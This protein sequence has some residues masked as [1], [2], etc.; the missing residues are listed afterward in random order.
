MHRCKCVW[1]NGACFRM[2]CV[3]QVSICT[4]VS[5]RKTFACMRMGGGGGGKEGLLSSSAM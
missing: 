1:W 5:I 4:P 2:L 3:V